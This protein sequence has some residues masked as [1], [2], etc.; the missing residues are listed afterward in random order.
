M[1]NIF[2][3]KDQSNSPNSK[4]VAQSCSAQ[5]LSDANTASLSCEQ[6]RSIVEYQSDIIVLIAADDTLI[7]ANK[8]CREFYGI[9]EN[10]ICE[11]NYL[12]FIPESER[13]KV[14]EQLA[15][16]TKDSP[17]VMVDNRVIS[18]SGQLRWVRWSNMAVFDNSTG[19]L[20]YIQSVG[21]DITDEKE[22]YETLR[23]NDERFQAILHS[24]QDTA[25]LMIDEN[26][27]ITYSWFGRELIDRYQIISQ[28][29]GGFERF[30]D[31]TPISSSRLLQSVEYV[32][33]NG[34]SLG[35]QEKFQISEGVASFEL[36]LS[37]LHDEN[38]KVAS[39]V[40]YAKDNSMQCEAQKLSKFRMRF[41]SI[42]M[43]MST[44]FIDLPSQ[45]IETGIGETLKAIC[46]FMGLERAFLYELSSADLATLKIEWHKSEFSDLRED[47]KNIAL[48]DFPVV[49]S[50]LMNLETVLIHRED[51]IE[52]LA[53][54]TILEQEDA[55]TLLLV[56]MAR[57]GKLLGSLGFEAI[58]E[59]K[60]WGSEIVNLFKL[61]AEVLTNV[62]SRHEAELNLRESEERF[63][64]VFES[65]D[66]RIYVWDKN[67]ILLYANHSGLD[68]FK[69][70]K[71]NAFG[72]PV[73]QILNNRPEFL[74]LW[75]ERV[76]KVLTT[77]E[78]IHVHDH[79]CDENGESWTSSSLSP[80]C[81]INGDVFAVAIL[82]RD[83]TDSEQIKIELSLYR[84]K[85]IRTEQL[86][87]LGVLGATVSHELNQPLTV[88]KLLAQQS[89]RSLRKAKKMDSIA[90]KNL[91]ESLD[92]IDNAS[93]IVNRFR[94]FARKMPRDCVEQIDL[95]KN[96]A[97]I[98][99][100]LSASAKKAGLAILI[101]GFSKLPLVE[102]NPGE[103]DQL[104]FI[105]I[106]NAIQAIDT[107]KENMLEIIA[108]ESHDKVSIIFKDNCSGI[109]E[110]ELA[111]IFEP[112]FTT[113]SPKEGT[114]LGLSI[115]KELLEGRGGQIQVESKRGIGTC[116][117]VSFP[118]K[119]N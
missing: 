81:D 52:D 84:E 48:S 86:A 89:L 6:F 100:A 12:A 10:A 60:P 103:L 98:V 42:L 2:P 41:E 56:P 82:A 114:G 59:Q 62:L 17:T 8:T 22:I 49:A 119:M 90:V 75:Q 63:K 27:Q 39:V 40:C 4:P 78:S 104:F 61:A 45:Q 1:E 3:N 107:H 53:L 69:S 85:M 9:A 37:P 110:E 101:N 72:K 46:E 55:K 23:R 91:Q 115:V 70:S 74:A 111:K 11:M 15:N 47:V 80:L 32:L 20:A 38:G 13:V 76:Q 28:K 92:E 102:A 43:N 77:G 105:M 93:R 30:F 5:I 95:K 96:L 67:D 58:H 65:T 50:K 66:D 79:I 88:L 16:L 87:S 108:S 99:A 112:F 29:V 97:K 25:I 19:E 26:K 94:V 35:Y 51:E 106:Q 34:K 116:F 83:T 33:A 113:K 7:Y 54:R 21:R 118:V 14:G 36:T 117:E 24:M 68:A 18:A 73:S 57:D 44:Y 71:A 64:A 31:F 109:K